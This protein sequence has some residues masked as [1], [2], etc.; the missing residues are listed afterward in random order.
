MLVI[1]ANVITMCLLYDDCSKEYRNNLN[2]VNITFSIVFIIEAVI[3]IVAL[4]KNYF[5]SRSNNFDLFLV[6]LSIIDL[7]LDAL[8]DN[9]SSSTSAF[10]ILP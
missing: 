6:I 10:S 4:G 8:L 3:K 5:F 2:I 9:H 1:I 7:S